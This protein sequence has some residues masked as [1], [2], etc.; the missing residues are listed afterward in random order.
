M[1]RVATHLDGGGH[2]TTVYDNAMPDEVIKLWTEQRK[3]VKFYKVL[4]DKIPMSFRVHAVDNDERVSLFDL[5]DWM[6]P[7]LNDWHEG[8]SATSPKDQF[9]RSFINCY[10]KG[11]HIRGHVDLHPDEW[12]DEDSYC[13][14][15]VFLTPDSYIN[16]PGDCGFAVTDGPDTDNN[17]VVPNKFNRLILMDARCYHEPIVPSDNF[18]RLTLYAGYTVSPLLKKRDLRMEKYRILSGA[19]PGTNYTFDLE[20]YV[21]MD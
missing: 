5:H 14:A 10:Q 15:L 1:E 11:D 4:Q 3:Q 20:D 18:Q 7:Y 6:G 19:V 8:L 12:T 9:V 16:D 2:L 17:F 13:V 21:Y